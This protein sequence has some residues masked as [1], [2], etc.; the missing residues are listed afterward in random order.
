MNLQRKGENHRSLHLALTVCIAAKGDR[1]TSNQEV[2]EQS[3]TTSMLH[4]NTPDPGVNSNASCWIV[5]F[6]QSDRISV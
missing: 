4:C 2:V 5:L 6:N 1:H 3:E